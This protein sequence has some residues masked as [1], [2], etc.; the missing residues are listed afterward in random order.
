MLF[1]IITIFPD[2]FRSMLEHGVLKRAL[3]GGQIDVRI[4]DLRDFTHDVHRTVDDRPFGG[5]PG[6][7]LKPE[8]LFLA[9]EAIRSEGAKNSQGIPTEPRESGSGFPVVL[10]TPQG[11]LLRQP[12]VESLAAESRLV[13]I[14]GRYEG[15]DQRV[16]EFLATDEISIGDY[17]LSGGE[18][19][20]AVVVESCT[21]LLPGVMGNEE[22]GCCESFATAMPAADLEER[23]KVCATTVPLSGHEDRDG[24]CPP[25]PQMGSVT[26]ESRV[27][28]ELLDFPHYT[29]PADFRGMRVPEVLLSG[30]HGQIRRWRRRQSLERTWRRRPELLQ[31]YALGEE[32]RHLLEEIQQS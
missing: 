3:A 18:L 20:A 15:V 22:S 10:L 23:E 28:A 6:M 32:D 9:V 27:A 14:C 29:R 8:P 1:D 21:R 2:F 5:G 7:L 31:H 12:V 16:A 17:V 30:N 26:R 19:A 4:H 25:L 13:L 24:T 11:R